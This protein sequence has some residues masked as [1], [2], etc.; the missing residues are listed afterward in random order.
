MTFISLCPTTI[1]IQFTLLWRNEI[2]R[3]IIMTK[4]F[5]L[6]LSF[7]SSSSRWDFNVVCV[8]F[9]LIFAFIFFSL[10]LSLTHS[11]IYAKQFPYSSVLFFFDL[12]FHYEYASDKS[13]I[14]PPVH[15]WDAGRKYMLCILFFFFCLTRNYFLWYFFFHILF[16]L[17]ACFCRPSVELDYGY[18][19]NLRYINCII[20][21]S[22]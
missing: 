20:Q 14:A 19:S 15:I 21:T 11:L 6:F 7:F 1:S 8:S 16:V 4:I 22:S 2:N 18:I 3:F 12:W 17:F 9:A 5:F 13:R 10:T